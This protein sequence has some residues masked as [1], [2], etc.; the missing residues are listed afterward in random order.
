VNKSNKQTCLNAKHTFCQLAYRSDPLTPLNVSFFTCPNSCKHL[1]HHSDHTPVRPHERI[2]CCDRCIGRRNNTATRFFFIN[3]TFSTTM[4]KL[5]TPSMYCW[6]RKTLV[7]I[8]SI[9]FR[10]NDIC[11][12]FFCPQKTSNRTLFLILTGCFQRQRCLILMFI[13]YLMT[14]Q[15]CHRNKT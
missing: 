12:K 8:H 14:S 6:S 3:N 4:S 11:V 1:S 13:K 9:R 7:T 2:D 5:F 10:L 15:W